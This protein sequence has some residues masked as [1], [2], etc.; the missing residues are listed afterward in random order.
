MS[1]EKKSEKKEDKPEIIF[2]HLIS[3]PGAVH[4]I[5]TEKK[6]MYLFISPG[7]PSLEE[8]E[9]I[10]DFLAAVVKKSIEQRTNAEKEKFKKVDEKEEKVPIST[11]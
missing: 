10:T 4:H 9:E 7:N 3:V 2:P 5:Y 8:L 1:E 11:K 6:G